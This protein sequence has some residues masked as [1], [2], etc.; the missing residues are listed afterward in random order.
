MLNAG[1]PLNA[2]CTA[3]QREAVSPSP[4]HKGIQQI[5]HT[6]FEYLARISNATEFR[7]FGIF[8]RK[9]RVEYTIYAQI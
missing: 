4:K 9:Q 5:G 8:I 3:R 2:I 7:C 6:L 1:F